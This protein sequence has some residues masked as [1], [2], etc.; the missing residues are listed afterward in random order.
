M[1]SGHTDRETINRRRPLTEGMKET[2][3]VIRRRMLSVEERGW[4][5]ALSRGELTTAEKNHVRGL[6][7]RG[8]VTTI[9]DDNHYQP[10]D[11]GKAVEI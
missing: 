10:T 11:T 4:Q 5:Q 8:F 6:I 7:D 3:R 9:G 2:L 1:P